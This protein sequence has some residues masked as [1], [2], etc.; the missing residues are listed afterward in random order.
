MSPM[1]RY[2]VFFTG[3][4]QFVGFR[5]F[6][7]TSAIKFSITGWVKNLDNGLVEMEAQGSE[8]NLKLFFNSVKSGNGFSKVQDYSMKE[9]PIIHNEEEM[10]IR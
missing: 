10:K 1:K 3:R 5:Y 2:L 8:E 6:C 4:V 7:I 9:I